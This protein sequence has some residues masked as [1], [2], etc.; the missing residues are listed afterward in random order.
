MLSRVPEPQ[1]RAAFAAVLAGGA[2][3]RMGEPKPV[4]E[5]VGR[6]LITYPIEAVRAAGLEPVVVAKPDTVLPDLS[7]R[8]VH[9]RDPRSHPAA[10]IVAAVRAADGAPVV[11]LAC[12]MPFVR[13]QLIDFL[14]DSEAAVAIPRVRGRLE[15]LLAR[16]TPAAIPMLEAAIEHQGPLQEAA[17]A[18]DPLIV[19]EAELARF[20]EPERM[21]SN[22]NDRA[23]LASAEQL[24]AARAI[25]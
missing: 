7:C 24:I 25:R 1:G 21:T 9:D 18:L 20:G 11:V 13:P 23:A 14:A 17:A 19:E 16:Y 12:D 15:P 22:V 5:L 3:A 6:P 4:I 10:G 2:S 8:V